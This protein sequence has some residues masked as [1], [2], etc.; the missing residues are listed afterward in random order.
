M[1]GETTAAS[2]RTRQGSEKMTSP[3]AASRTSPPRPLPRL[4][5]GGGAVRGRNEV[6][7]EEVA[8]EVGEI[9]KML[10]SAL[11]MLEESKK[12]QEGLRG[13]VEAL[14]R[15]V[16]VYEALKPRSHS[17]SRKDVLSSSG[18]RLSWEDE[19]RPSSP[20]NNQP[21]DANEDE[22]GGGHVE[23]KES[24]Q[25]GPQPSKIHAWR[26]AS[27]GSWRNA[28][29]AF[30]NGIAP[31]ESFDNS[32]SMSPLE[33]PVHAEVQG[34]KGA[35]PQSR[36]GDEDQCESSES[37]GVDG[38]GV[39]GGPSGEFSL[40]L[41]PPQ[42]D[43][44]ARAR[45]DDD[46]EAK[47]SAGLDFGAMES[48]HLE[49]RHLESRHLESRH[50][51]SRHLES[52]HLESRHLE[53]N[54]AKL[55]QCMQE[56]KSA[57]REAES[58]RREA[59]SVLS[60]ASAALEE[61]SLELLSVRKSHESDVARL[62]G[63]AASAR[64]ELTVCEGELADEVGKREALS[65]DLASCRQQLKEARS[66]LKT[67]SSEVLSL[68]M[69]EAEGRELDVGARGEGSGGEEEV[70][71]TVSRWELEGAEEEI[72]E[73]RVMLKEARAIAKKKEEEVALVRS[74]MG[75]L[76]RQVRLGLRVEG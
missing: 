57:R 64:A 38:A 25:Q 13:Q 43:S 14:T 52:R 70:E 18:R 68:R 65:A 7:K 35:L 72:K 75:V 23:R 53:L 19:H 1:G 67:A 62:L 46:E 4:A 28:G 49:S 29:V 66:E 39:G 45:G 37:G 10:Q 58:A 44:D 32:P 8:G 47:D 48:R 63:D 73:L 26:N 16:V 71:L 74:E 51:E 69:R 20:K 3:P 40:L 6:S 24:G 33:S 22:G 59:E 21:V 34:G 56:A 2:R 31:T 55:A 9:A 15:K 61:L 30:W 11:G 76:R 17:P 5:G 60:G 54:R 12:E 42:L 27:E 41:P 50:L 36:W